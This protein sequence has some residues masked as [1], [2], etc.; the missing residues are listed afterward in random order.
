MSV[1]AAPNAPT[2][3]RAHAIALDLRCRDFCIY[4]EV[5]TDLRLTRFAISRKR[6]HLERGNLGS[7]AKVS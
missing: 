5:V 1:E 2:S 6:G 3:I 7:D 4:L